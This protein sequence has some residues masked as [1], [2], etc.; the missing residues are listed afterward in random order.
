M[1]AAGGSG[2]GL[3]KAA[4]EKGFYAIGVDSDQDDI[5]QGKILTSMLKRVDNGVYDIIKD[6]KDGKFEAGVKYIGLAEEGLDTTEF[7]YTKDIIGKE[8]LDK[9][10]Q[11]K[12]DI[13]DGKIKVSDKLEK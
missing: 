2:S 3:F 4:E 9:I 7:K 8:N 11:I 12:Q 13:K 10:A 6:L 5:V 1:H